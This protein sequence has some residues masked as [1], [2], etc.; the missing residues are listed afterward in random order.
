MTLGADFNVLMGLGVHAAYDM[1]KNNN[2]WGV[3]A[4]LNFRLPSM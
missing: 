4:H 2:T 1:G 3:G